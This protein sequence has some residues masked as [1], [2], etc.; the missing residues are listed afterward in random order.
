MLNLP[1]GLSKEVVLPWI[2]RKQAYD[3]IP[4]MIYANRNELKDSKFITLPIPRNLCMKTLFHILLG[5][6]S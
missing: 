4:R 5:T 1:I 2:I 6:A 3:L